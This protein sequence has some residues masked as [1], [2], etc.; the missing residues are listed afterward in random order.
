MTQEQILV[1]RSEFEKNDHYFF[2]QMILEIYK[3]KQYNI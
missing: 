2:Y 3:M 1:L